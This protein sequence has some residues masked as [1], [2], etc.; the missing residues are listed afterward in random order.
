MFLELDGVLPRNSLAEDSNEEQSEGEQWE[1]SENEDNEDRQNQEE[2]MATYFQSIFAQELKSN[3]ER[4]AFRIIKD[5]VQNDN[6]GPY[7]P[8]FFDSRNAKIRKP[9]L[10]LLSEQI[11]DAQRQKR[12]GDVVLKK[13]FSSS[14]Q[15]RVYM[16]YSKDALIEMA[17]STNGL[18]LAKTQSAD[19]MIDKII[20][21]DKN[22]ERQHRGVNNAP[23]HQTATMQSIHENDSPIKQEII[24]AFL[25]RSFMKPLKGAQ[26]EHCRMGHVLELPI[27]KSWMKD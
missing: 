9:M 2:E 23:T 19:T 22:Q 18:S 16:F 5:R 26:R 15:R 10:K 14:N 6:T 8:N 1:D 25:K 13:W 7:A 11:P 3:D 12:Y 21:A 17:A 24:T 4:N 27:G 20:E